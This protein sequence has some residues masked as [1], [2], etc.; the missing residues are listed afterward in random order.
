[1]KH[2][3]P[4]ISMAIAFALP[5]KAAQEWV[6]DAP[7]STLSFTAQM[8]E[9]K[10]T[11]HF[12]KFNSSIR[13]SPDDL[14]HSVITTTVAVAS[15]VT[16]AADRDSALPESQWF[17]NAKFPEA[18]FVTQS[19]KATGP[20]AYLAEAK[21]TLRGVSK[22]VALPFTL[23]TE[24]GVTHAVGSVTIQRNDYGVGQGE[25]ASDAWVKFP[26]AI[27]IDLWAKPKT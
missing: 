16:G 4:L 12:K 7:R 22:D 15:A 11:G 27:A 20:N 18:H 23:T 9:D 8:G 3:L 6:V 13:F 21:L 1:M 14:A 2:V 19:I 17:D 25:F 5:A 24:N 26:V 10:F